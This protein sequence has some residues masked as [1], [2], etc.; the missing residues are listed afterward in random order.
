MLS[1]YCFKRSPSAKIFFEFHAW[2][3]KCHFGNFSV[4]PKY[5]F[6]TRAWNSKFFLAKRLL[7]R[8][9]WKCHIQNI[10]IPCSRVRQIHDLGQSKYKLRLFSKRRC[11]FLGIHNCKKTV[12]NTRTCQVWLF[13]HI[14]M[15]DALKTIKASGSKQTFWSLNHNICYLPILI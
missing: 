1:S 10:S 2:V 7:L 8:A 3:Q 6:W 4:L 14:K 9:L 11:L 13:K 12:W 5:H 15:D